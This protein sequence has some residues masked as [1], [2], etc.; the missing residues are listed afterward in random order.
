MITHYYSLTFV[1]FYKVEYVS[2][3][4]RRKYGVQFFERFKS[5]V[6]SHDPNA[7]TKLGSVELFGSTATKVV[8]YVEAGM[9]VPVKE[10]GRKC[11]RLACPA[12]LVALTTDGKIHEFI[13]VGSE[14][15]YY[16]YYRYLADSHRES[17]VSFGRLM[18]FPLD[19]T[20]IPSEPP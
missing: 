18:G 20:D 5:Y 1:I 19:A 2:P 13:G 12:A 15:C 6:A 7:N 16:D 9:S 4:V 17:L 8:I 3:P 10:I 11:N 14:T